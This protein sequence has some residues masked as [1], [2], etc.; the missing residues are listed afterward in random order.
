MPS[1]PLL[2]LASDDMEHKVRAKL[3]LNP[4]QEVVWNWAVSDFSPMVRQ[5]VKGS[6]DGLGAGINGTVY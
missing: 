6:E 5:L 1:C 2:Q 3:G 4:H